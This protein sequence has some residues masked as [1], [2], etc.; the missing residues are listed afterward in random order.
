MRRHI[1]TRLRRDRILTP[2]QT[3]HGLSLRIKAQP[4]LSIKR[5][6]P[7]PR[8][9]LLISRE[10]EHRQRHG[11]RDVYPDLAGL[12]VLLEVAGGRPAAGENGDAVAVFVGVDE[13]D[14]VVDGL[15]V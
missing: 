10:A 9:T 4:W 12:D 2:P 15:D 6:R 13:G 14:G 3:R 11:D 7:S 5:I 8:N 1:N